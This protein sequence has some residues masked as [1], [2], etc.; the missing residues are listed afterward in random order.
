MDDQ[1]QNFP[2][3]PGKETPA[4]ESAA[5]PPTEAPE[6]FAEMQVVL[7]PPPLFNTRAGPQPAR[8]TAIYLPPMFSTAHAH[9]EF[10]L[11]VPALVALIMLA[12]WVNLAGLL[13][14]L[15]PVH[16]IAIM[17]LIIGTLATI[18][19]RLSPDIRPKPLPL[20]DLPHYTV[21]VPLYDEANMLPQLKRS[22]AALIYPADR[23]E[24]LLL[25]EQLMKV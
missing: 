8:H 11:F 16:I 22:L 13:Y 6:G 15:W 3:K 24:I 7:D 19:I 12:G 21:L 10:R 25:M 20:G 17:P 1:K 14:V 4:Q 5:T 23:L 18:H 9:R 2:T